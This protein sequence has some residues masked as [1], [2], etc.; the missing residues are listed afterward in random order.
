MFPFLINKGEFV[1]PTFFFMIMLASLACTFYVYWLAGR[2][3]YSQIAILDIAIFG[4]IF[5]F[6]GARLFHILV[7]APSYYAQDLWRVFYVWQGGF[8]GYGVFI[9]VTLSALAY[10]KIRKLPILDYV[11]LIALGCPLI[12]FIVRIGCIGAGCCYGKPTD[13]FFHL[14]FTD[15]ASDAARQFAGQHLHATQ[16]YDM[17]NA[18]FTFTL[19][20]LV[21]RRKQF[22]GQVALVFFMSYAFFRFWIEFLRGDADRGLYFNNSISTSQITG[23]VIIAL[24][25]IL[26]LVLS[27]KKA[28]VAEI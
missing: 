21:D 18:A 11:D 10:L 23:I 15:P 25:S 14:T 19:I 4:T 27:K 5:G 6:I 28:V 9:G 3:G 24:C 22:K 8:V 20:H 12:I 13:F 26:Y 7:E 1:I 17:L 2:R 16:I